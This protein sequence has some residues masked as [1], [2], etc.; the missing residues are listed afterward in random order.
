[1][2]ER[3]AVDQLLDYPKAKGLDYETHKSTKRFLLIQP[4]RNASTKYVLFKKDELTFFAYDSY[5]QTLTGVYALSNFENNVEYE[6]TKKYW[7]DIFRTGK[8]KTGV[9]R[10]DNKLTIT[11][12]S[13]RYIRK[14]INERV[15]S[16]FMELTDKVTPVK[17]LVK[18]DYLRLIEDFK[19]EN[20]IGLETN[21][22]IYKTE[23]IEALLDIGGEIIEE[24]KKRKL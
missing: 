13:D 14:C 18:T 6:I 8:I 17:L 15:T 21:R 3:C 5:G 19:S 11:S 22:W 12:S 1:M 20:I 10:I 16:L 2:K 9:K 23:D 24:L 4:Y 7:L